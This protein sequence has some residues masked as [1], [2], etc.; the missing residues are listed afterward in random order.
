MAYRSVTHIALHVSSLDEAEDF[1]VRLFA[2]DVVLREEIVMLSRESF[3]LALE[4]VRDGRDFSEGGPLAHIGLHVSDDELERMEQAADELGCQVARA[5]ADLL[6]I[7]D[8]YGVSW[9]VTSIWPPASL[10]Q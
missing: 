10:S 7:M 9:E 2:L 5:R 3:S 1:Y 8:R 4:P 6:L